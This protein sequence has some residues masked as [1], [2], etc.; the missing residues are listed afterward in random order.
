MY[1]AKLVKLEVTKVAYPRPDSDTL[2][3]EIQNVLLQG[4]TNFLNPEICTEEGGRVYPSVIHHLLAYFV[5][6][7]IGFTEFHDC[8]TATFFDRG[9]KC[10]AEDT[11]Y[12]RPIAQPWS[13]GVQTQIEL[14]ST[15]LSTHATK[16]PNFI[17]DVRM[18]ACVHG[19]VCGCT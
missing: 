8:L 11:P 3:V 18:C 10:I 1:I 15:R 13:G 19:R 12:L 4:S 7:E 9:A 6:P 5:P 17:S 14:L 16:P 2:L